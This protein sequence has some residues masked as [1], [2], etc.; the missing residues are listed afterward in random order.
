MIGNGEV[1]TEQSDDGADQ[2][3]GLPQRQAEHRSQCQRRGDCQSRIAWLATRCR[4]RLSTPGRDRRLGEPDCQAAA[5]T[6]RCVIVRPVRHPVPLSR[7]V[8]ATGGIGFERHDGLPMSGTAATSIPRG[9]RHQPADPCNKVA[10]R[11]TMHCT[12]MPGGGWIALGSISRRSARS[13][14]PAGPWR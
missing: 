6:K 10:C 12:A 9:S 8:V 14:A 2:S 11:R 7:D 13:A 4:P 3:F 5:L 1:E